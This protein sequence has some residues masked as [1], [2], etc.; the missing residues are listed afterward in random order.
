MHAADLFGDVE[1]GE[2]ACNAQH[3]VIA[4]RRKPHRVGGVADQ[5]KPGIVELRDFLE[6]GS[7]RLRVGA[8][9]GET[10]RGV[11]CGLRITRPR[12]A[13]R[14][15]AAAFRRGRQ[16]QVGGGHRRHLDMQVNAV[17]QRA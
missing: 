12:H 11:A 9:A 3:T 7:M 15:L 6:R 14:H 17:D 10:Q 8:D 5:R 1:I 4:A 2:R 16:D 13:R